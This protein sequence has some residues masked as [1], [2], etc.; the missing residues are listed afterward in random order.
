M[1]TRIA[2]VAVLSVATISLIIS[3]VVTPRPATAHV[4]P[5]TN[6]TMSTLTQQLVAF[7][8]SAT[9]VGS[10]ADALLAPITKAKPTV[11]PTTTPAPSP[12]PSPTPVPAPSPTP[13]PAPAPAPAA[14]TPTT[15]AP[16][17]VTDS[18][19]T[20]TANWDCI[21]VHESGDRYNDPSAPSGAYGIISVTWH[22]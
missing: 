13:V 14:T 15:A 2:L 6:G 17:A 22:S 21:R 19:S 11:V 16:V 8:V 9:S 1:R 12:A 10:P 20:A 7:R 4:S 3:T 5:A 18:T